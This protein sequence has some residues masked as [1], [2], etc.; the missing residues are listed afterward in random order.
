[1]V[2]RAFACLALGELLELHASGK[3]DDTAFALA[4]AQL[5]AQ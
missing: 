3:I 2:F 5:A 4:D 1:M